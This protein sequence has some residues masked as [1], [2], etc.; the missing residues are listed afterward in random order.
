MIKVTLYK[1]VNV[2]S[3]ETPLRFRLRDGKD[4]DLALE[5]GK[6]VSAKDLMTF[7]QDG[8]VQKGVSVYNVAL[9]RDIDRYMSVMSEVYLAMIQEGE[10]IDDESFQKAVEVRLAEQESGTPAVPSLVDRY[11]KYLKEEHELGRFSDKM[12]RESYTISRKLERYLVIRERAGLKPSDFT[13]EMVVDFEKFC[14]DEYLYA[15][16]PKYADLYPRSYEECRYWP[17]H[18]LKEEPLRKMLLHFQAFWNDLVLFGEIERSPYEGYVPWM[19]EKPQKWYSEMMGEPMTLT[20][21]EF[22]QV[23]ATPVPERMANVRNAFILQTCIGCRGEDF[24]K[25]KMKNVAVSKRGIPY[26]RYSHS[27]V[28]KKEKNEYE[29][30][31]EVPLVR[32]AFDIVM[33]TR[34]DFHFGRRPDP[35]NK[36]IQ[37]FLRFCGIT[38]EVCV[39]NNRTHQAERVPLCDAFTQ[40]HIHPMHLDIVRESEC[41]RGMRGIGFTGARVMEK[42]KKENIEDQFWN[43]NWAFGQKSFRVDENLNIIE[44]VPFAERDTMIFQE[45]P[46]KLPGGRTNPYVLSSMEPMPAGD[47][48]QQERVTIRNGCALLQPRKVVVCGNQFVEFMESLEDEHRRWIQYGIMLLKILSDFQ[49]TFLRDC[50]D[51]IYELQSAPRGFLYSVYFYLN[52]DKVV[53]VHGCLTEK[54]RRHKASGN[55]KMPVVREL[56]WKHVTGGISDENYDMVLDEVFGERGT[57]KRE[58]WEM[59]ACCAYVSQALRQARIDSGMLQE[60]LFSKWGLKDDSGAL[61]HGENGNRVLPYKYLNRHLEGL[62]LKAAIVRPGLIDW[63]TISRT[64]TL[65]DMRTSIGETVYRWHRKEPDEQ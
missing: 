45:Q 55:G 16:N 11:R 32:V 21:D 46:D 6:M 61:A 43:L 60:E 34:F 25:L 4:V 20:M 36:K 5:S 30:D 38:R 53:L 62:G 48:K 42:R 8:S 54:H 63:N 39:Y 29:Y 1:G 44:G 51:T 35:Y 37:E 9:K 14:I 10:A 18:K 40:L 64:R 59:R 15:A 12:F 13:P 57:T 19:E 26:I 65:E 7:A 27:A 33:R 58:V 24:F 2:R 50:W 52:G 3:G 31:I 17:K 22:Q 47:A 49:V 28:R 56:R 41:L 23:I